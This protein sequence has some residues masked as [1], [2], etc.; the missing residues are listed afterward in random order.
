[1]RVLLVLAILLSLVA[2]AGFTLMRR[3]VSHARPQ[4]DSPAVTPVSH[5]QIESEHT[6]TDSIFANG[7]VEGRQ[8]ELALHFEITGR[9]WSVEAKEGA[10]VQQGTVL[11]RLDAAVLQA[12]VAKAQANLA[13]A[14]AE[15][16][17]LLAGARA[18]AKEYARAQTRL[19]KAELV[20][21]EKDFQR[22]EQLARKNV[23]TGQELDDAQ[24][25]YDMAR[26]KYEAA[27][28]KTQEIEASA[29]SE[30]VRI[31]EARVAFETANVHWAQRM[32]H[33]AQLLSPIDGVVLRRRGE[34]GELVGP[35]S[36]HPLVTMVDTSQLHARA[37][38][39]ELD[40]IAVAVGD[41]A[42]VQAD[43]LPG[44]QF[45]GH[46]VSCSPYM[47]AKQHFQNKP[48]ER[49]DVKTR[50]VLIELDSADQPERLVIGLPVD[51]Y[52]QPAAL[53]QVN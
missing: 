17:L 22:T 34:P 42:Y 44:I 32:L 14:Q 18:E 11:A 20:K 38:V 23:S 31:A 4:A 28:A 13:K 27:L 49:E 15:L 45:R 9:L 2:A 47:V 48:A 51:V 46:V 8:R 39:E 7:I 33:K 16:E 40:A 6:P 25:S 12:D 30:E 50:E 52:I 53:R 29:R 21:A 35:T 19:A 26:A 5:K 36:P 37:F 3:P 43:G 24:A 41:P 10:L 1:M